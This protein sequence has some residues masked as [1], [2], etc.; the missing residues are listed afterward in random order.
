MLGN[1]EGHQKQTSVWT[2]WLDWVVW[3]KVI[4]RKHVFLF[5]CNCPCKMIANTYSTTGVIWFTIKW[6][7]WTSSLNESFREN[8]SDKSFTELLSI[9]NSLTENEVIITFISISFL[10]FVKLK[11][12]IVIAGVLTRQPVKDRHLQFN[13][14]FEIMIFQKQYNF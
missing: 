6:L 1:P 2:M 7:L 14:F 5:T 9:F 11:N 13:Y 3:H 4:A 8:H 12:Y 10:M